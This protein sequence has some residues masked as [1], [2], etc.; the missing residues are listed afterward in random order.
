[1]NNKGISL[2]EMIIVCAIV[3]ILFPAVLQSM[4]VVSTYSSRAKIET[5]L[6]MLANEK[7]E[8][9]KAVPFDNLSIGKKVITI[10]NKNETGEIIISKFGDGNK[11]NLKK[12]IVIVSHEDGKIKCDAKLVTLIAR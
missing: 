4:K 9:L 2:L 8:E 10:D 12:I 6:I 7:I 5:R 3:A 1:M 11:I